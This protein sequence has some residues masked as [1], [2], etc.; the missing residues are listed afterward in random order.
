[1]D[2]HAH[3]HWDVLEN[4]MGMLCEFHPSSQLFECRTLQKIAWLQKGGGYKWRVGSYFHTHTCIKTNAITVVDR[5]K[6]SPIPTIHPSNFRQ[7]TQHENTSP[8]I[9]GFRSGPEKGRTF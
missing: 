6:K 3:T 7:P 5:S 8:S 2:A 1:M 9:L 4:G